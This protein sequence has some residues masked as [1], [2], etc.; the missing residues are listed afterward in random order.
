VYAY[1]RYSVQ[2]E[3]DVEI[4]DKKSDDCRATAAK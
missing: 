2:L 1:G 3:E 4:Q